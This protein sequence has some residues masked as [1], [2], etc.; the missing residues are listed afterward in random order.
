VSAALVEI[1]TI[2]AYVRARLRSTKREQTR[3]LCL[4]PNIGTRGKLRTCP[5]IKSR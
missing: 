4:G 1:R 5:L 3:A 2:L